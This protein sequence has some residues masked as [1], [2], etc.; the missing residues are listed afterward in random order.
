MSKRAGS[1]FA[2]LHPDYK[3]AFDK[4]IVGLAEQPRPYNAEKMK[5]AKGYDQY[6]IRVRD[7][8]LVYDVKDDKVIV[9]ILHI[10]PRGEVYKVRRRGKR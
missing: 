2:R 8:R 7:F 5:G 6:R 3:K 4:I 9:L 10:S 1:E